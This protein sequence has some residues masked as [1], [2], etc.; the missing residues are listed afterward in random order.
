[1]RI[2][3]ILVS[4]AALA[5]AAT[6]AALGP[7]MRFGLWDLSTAFGL[8]RQ[9]TLPTLIAAGAAGVAFL[10]S[11]WK[12]RG[13]AL[14]SVIALVAAGAAGYAPVKM[15]AMAKANPVIHDIT[16]DF[17]NPPEI[18]AAAALP[19]KNPPDYVGANMVGDTQTTVADAQRQAFPDIA[20]FMAP[21]DLQSTATAA[22]AV[23]AD[24]GMNILEEG[25]VGA[26]A[27]TGWRIEAVSTSLW[28]GFKDDFIVRLT[29]VSAGETRVDVRSKSRVGGSDLG[30]NAARVRAFMKELDAAI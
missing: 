26:E 15:R 24:M 28:F 3:I 30:A 17:E 6:L 29:P 16:T 21:A 12:A 2:I 10:L 27:G 13:L 9:L 5:L 1:M 7:G 19:R 22:R 18:L 11:L 20:P 25:P 4:I 14:L 23:I 8:M